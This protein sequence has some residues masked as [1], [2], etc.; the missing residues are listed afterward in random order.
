[1]IKPVRLQRSRKKGFKFI[2]PNGLP[3]VYVGRPSKF[4]NPYNDTV[5]G[6]RMLIE[7]FKNTAQGIWYPTILQTYSNESVRWVYKRHCEWLERIG[8]HPLEA[9]RRELKGKNLSCWCPLDKP[10]HADILLELANKE[11]R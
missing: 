1:M 6:R 5:Y 3:I 4:G 2:S 10:C 9:I 7:L 8:E 11:E